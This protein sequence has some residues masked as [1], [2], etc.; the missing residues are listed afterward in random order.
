MGTYFVHSFKSYVCV[1]K[2]EISERMQVHWVP[3]KCKSFDIKNVTRLGRLSVEKIS[4]KAYRKSLNS[5]F[6][7]SFTL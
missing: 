7:T 6:S 2:W 1:K 5:F 4:I 3:K